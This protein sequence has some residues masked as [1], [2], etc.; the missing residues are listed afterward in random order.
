MDKNIDIDGFLESILGDDRNTGNI[1][2]GELPAIDLYMDQVTTFLEDRLRGMVRDPEAQKF[3]TKT[4]INNYA[5]NDLIPAPVNKKYT[6]EHLILLILIFY[7]KSF[8]SMEDI[9]KLLMPLRSDKKTGRQDD[10]S[11]GDLYSH[12]LDLEDSCRSS[13]MQ[14]IRDY[15]DAASKDLPFEDED[16]SIE[17]FMLLSLLSFDVYIKKL[18][19]ERLLDAGTDQKEEKNRKTG[20]DK[21]KKQSRI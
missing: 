5:K 19:I 21:R 14:Q 7:D 18:M 13:V 9:R 2:Y 15:A 4:M 6:R 8:L 20:S 16:G 11:P 17:R 1:G 10:P 3:L 12:L